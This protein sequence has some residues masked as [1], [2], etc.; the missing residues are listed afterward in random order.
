[1]ILVLLRLLVAL[2]G[3]VLI[4]LAVVL[5]MYEHA[6]LK[7]LNEGTSPPPVRRTLYEHTLRRWR[8]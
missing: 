3:V 4:S 5:C 6:F 1:M 2:A 8:S 7:H